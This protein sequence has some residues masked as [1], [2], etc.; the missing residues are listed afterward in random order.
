MAITVEQLAELVQGEIRGDG[1]VEITDA[2]I[3]R[4]VQPGEI[5]FFDHPKM[6]AT[7]CECEAAALVV[8]S[9]MKPVDKACIVVENVRDAFATIVKH[10]R[11]PR[12]T[13]FQGVHE[14]AV[15]AESAQL[16]ENVTVHAFAVIGEDVAIGDNSVIHSHCCI[17][18]GVQIG[19][20]AKIYPHV[21]IYEQNYIGDDCTIHAG[22]V[23]GANGF[24][25]DS[26]S[27]KHELTAQLGHVEIQDDVDVGANTTIDRG[28]Y[29]PTLISQ[30]AKLDNLVMIG[31][32]VLVGKYALLCGQVGVAGSSTIGNYVMLG[33]QVGIG[34]HVTICDHAIFGAQAGSNYDVTEKGIYLGTPSRKMREALTQYAALKKLPEMRREFMRL[35]EQVAKMSHP[36][37]SKAA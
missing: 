37:V 13:Q 32:N 18:D 3:L 25:Y 11:P 35:Q 12:F 10:F 1:G 8:S 29:G 26:A 19:K 36:A 15:I 34:D 14:Q 17:L 33:G 2:A 6:Y 5:S 22:A 27:G 4:D 20:N 21:V 24:G 23:I 28:S 16:G 30:G 31:H 9:D 7:A